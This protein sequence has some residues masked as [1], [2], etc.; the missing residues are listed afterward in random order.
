MIKWLPTVAKAIGAVV[1]VVLGA[2]VAGQIELVPWVEVVLQG[3]A[4]AL[5]VWAVPNKAA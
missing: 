5:V 2:A 1:A 3:I 4:A